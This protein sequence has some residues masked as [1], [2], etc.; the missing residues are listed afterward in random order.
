[1]ALVQTVSESV[2]DEVLATPPSSSE[3]LRLSHSTKGTD[4]EEMMTKNGKDTT[5]VALRDWG[6]PTF[7]TKEEFGVFVR[8]T[9]LEFPAPIN[10]TCILCSIDSTLSLSHFL[11][12]GSTMR[13]LI[14]LLTSLHYVYFTTLYRN[15]SVMQFLPAIKNFAQL[16]FPS[17]TRLRMKLMHFGA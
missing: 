16:C 1:M 13:F 17:R 4:E 14:S 7:L 5:K 6:Y 8:L 9:L 15:N 10:F 12:E 2:T 3:H 11:S